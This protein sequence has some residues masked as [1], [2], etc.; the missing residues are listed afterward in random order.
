MSEQET[1]ADIIREK[2]EMAAE[3]RAH[4]SI[5]PARR[6]DQLL[7]AD[8]LD[9]EADR[10]EAAWKRDE[11]HAVE[12]ATRHAEAVARDNCRDCVHNPRGKNFEGGNAAAMCDIV[13]ALANVI[14]PPRGKADEDGWLAWV[15]AMQAKARAALADATTKNSSAVGNAAAVREALEALVAYWDWNGYD[16]MRESRLKDMARSALAKPARN[17]DVG[18]AED[19]SDRFAD[20]CDSHSGCSQCPVKSL[21]NFAN[22][23]KPSCG[24]LWAQ[25]PYAA[26]EGGLQ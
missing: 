10:L 23:H 7:E 11:D 26:E 25:M 14:L 6:E 9:R 3:I 18:T 5:V 8:S 17:C 22:G 21:W 19:Q 16:A 20:F 15:R 1:I 2:R 4:L 24:V 13:T 12:H